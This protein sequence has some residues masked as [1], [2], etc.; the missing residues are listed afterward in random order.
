MK[1]QGFFAAG[2]VLA[3]LGISARAQTKSLGQVAR[4][5]R[6]QRAKEGVQAVK[7]YTNNNLPFKI[8]PFQATA[9]AS[10]K[11]ATAESKGASEPKIQTQIA[12]KEMTKQYWQARFQ[13]S[14]AAVKSAKEYQ[15]IA[16]E[17]LRLLH[18]QRAQTL[19]ATM[20]S[21]LDAQITA[22]NQQTSQARDATAKAE[23]A[24]SKLEMEFKASGAPA[25]WVKEN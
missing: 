19:N 12:S 13:A 24:L 17:E 5:Q 8:T 25:G 7:V 21:N 4:E 9:P 2:L 18:I 22:K 10:A 20:Q 11:G 16:E 14:N 6:E 15:R 3:A 23:Q 1:T